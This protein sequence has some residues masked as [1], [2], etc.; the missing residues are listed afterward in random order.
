MTSEKVKEAI[1]MF[2]SVHLLKKHGSH[3]VI[4]FFNTIWDNAFRKCLITTLIG[5]SQSGTT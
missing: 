3:F 4:S 2:I 1:P 5:G